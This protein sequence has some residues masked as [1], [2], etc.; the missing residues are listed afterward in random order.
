MTL[1][2][3]FYPYHFARAILSIPFCPMPFCQYT[4]LSV[5]FC[6]LPFCP[7]TD[8]IVRLVTWGVRVRTNPQMVTVREPPEQD[9]LD[10]QLLSITDCNLVIKIVGLITCRQKIIIITT[11]TMILIICCANIVPQ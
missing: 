7:R 3:I 8:Y 9:F 2:V 5:P 1:S 11:T 4:I 6:P 10:S